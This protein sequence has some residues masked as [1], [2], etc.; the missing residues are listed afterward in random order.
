MEVQVEACGAL[1]NLKLTNPTTPTSE[2]DAYQ[3]WIEKTGGVDSVI[4]AL[5]DLSTRCGS[6]SRAVRK[7]LKEIQKGRWQRD[8]SA[9]EK[10]LDVVAERCLA[11]FLHGEC[12]VRRQAADTLGKLGKYA[13]LAVPALTKCLDDQDLNV[14][15]S[16]AEA[17]GNLGRYAAPAVE[18]LAKCF[19]HGRMLSSV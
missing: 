8:A 14:C 13:V 1:T 10:A 4:D 12:E 3:C 6:D 16:A 11:E 15:V 18:A 7:L 17:L 2:D 9:R 19:K 5:R